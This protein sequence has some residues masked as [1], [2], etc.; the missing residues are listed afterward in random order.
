MLKLIWHFVRLALSLT[1][2]EDRLRLKN[3]QI[4]LAFCSACTIFAALF[5]KTR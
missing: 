4:N 3:A 2:I 5:N 1:A